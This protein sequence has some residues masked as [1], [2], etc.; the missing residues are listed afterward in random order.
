VCPLALSFGQFRTRGRWTDGLAATN[1]FF[2]SLFALEAA[3]K[4]YGLGPRAYLADM[5]NRYDCAITACSLI[6]LG[7]HNRVSTGIIL[8]LRV[9]RFARI[10]WVVS[11]TQTIGRLFKTVL[12]SLPA[13]WNVA[14]LILVCFY[15]FA[16]L[17]TCRGEV[18]KT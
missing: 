9:S 3:M 15:V 12:W 13:M 4:L 5:W 18:A 1:V 6:D 16:V 17:G 8:A 11:A 14:L 2:V 10:F 7:V